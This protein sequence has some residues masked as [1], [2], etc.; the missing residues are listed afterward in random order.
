MKSISDFVIKTVKGGIFFILPLVLVYILLGKAMHIVKPVAHFISSF[1]DRS[2]KG[3]DFLITAVSILI[4]VILCFF[5][6]LLSASKLGKSLV[7]WI[8]ENILMLFPGYSFL[9]SSMQ[10]TMGVEDVKNLPVKLA[11]ADGWVFCF[12][13]AELPNNELAV[14]IPGAPDPSS[15]SVSIYAKEELRDVQL[16][17]KEVLQIIRQNGVGLKKL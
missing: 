14:Y 10:S 16:T 2:G 13:M 7:Q 3:G 15:G 1:L 12:V 17:Q 9:K 5:F 11:P 6:G 8:E 4:V